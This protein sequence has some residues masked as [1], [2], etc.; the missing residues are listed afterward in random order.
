MKIPTTM[1][2]RKPGHRGGARARRSRSGRLFLTQSSMLDSNEA[3]RS[4]AHGAGGR[5]AP[6][7]LADH[8]ADEVLDLEH[9]TS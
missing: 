6:H 7:R 5:L 8:E 4:D 2:L 9:A 3:K 1:A